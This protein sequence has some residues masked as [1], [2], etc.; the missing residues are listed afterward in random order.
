MLTVSVKN[1]GPLTEGTVDLKPLT[2][3]VGPSNTGKSYMATAVSAVMR[4]ARVRYPV[5]GTFQ[6]GPLP[7]TEV[8]IPFDEFPEEIRQAIWRGVH[9]A[10]ENA[11]NVVIE[12]LS[13]CY[14]GRNQFTHRGAGPSGFLLQVERLEQPFRMDISLETSTVLPVK[15]DISDMRFSRMVLDHIIED[16]NSSRK[17]F[18]I[19]TS[20]VTRALELTFAGFPAETYY[21]PAARSGIIQAQKVLASA[22]VR[23]ASFAGIRELNVPTMPRVTTEFLSNLISLER[24]MGKEQCDS[25]REAIAFIETQVL[26]GKID[27]DESAGLPFP[28]IAYEG[29]RRRNSAWSIR[30]QWYRNWPR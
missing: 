15:F 2:I 5:W 27:L 22:L 29:R 9:T 30:P 23:Q 25:L 20:L 19:S 11:R 17:E 8:E 18:F 16:A 26:H 13:L 6:F 3:F 12:Q 4:A 7:D 10:M 24:Q 21:L 28:D 14:G 1:F